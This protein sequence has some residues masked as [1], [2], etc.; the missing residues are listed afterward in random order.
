MEIPQRLLE[1]AFWELDNE[2]D[3]EILQECQ[4]IAGSKEHAR[5]LYIKVRAMHFMMLEKKHRL[6]ETREL[7][8]AEELWDQMKK[9][10]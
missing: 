9:D 3:D 1:D 8:K 5:Q 7:V 2:P 4:E 10:L 6:E